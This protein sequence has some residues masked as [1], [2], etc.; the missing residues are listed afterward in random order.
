MHATI[1]V[2]LTVSIDDDKMIPLATLAEF[3]TDQNVES[4][5]L[6]GLVESL[7]ASRV[8]ALCGEKHAHGNGDQRFQRAGTDTRTAVTTAGEHEFNLH[9]VE[10][11]AAD[12]DEPSYFRPVEDV[13]SFD[14]QNRYQR[15]IAAKS[16][17]LATSLSYCDAAD[18]GD[19]IFERMPSPTTINR[20]IKEYG[21]KLKQFLPDFVADTDADA[22]IPDGTKCHSQD[23]DRSYHSV[24]ATLG[25]DTAEESRSLLDLSVNA[26][27]NETAADLYDIDAVTDDA[28]WSVTLMT[29]SLRPLPTNTAITNLI[30]S[31]LAER[32]TTTSGTTAVFSLD[33]RN[34]VVSE[35]I[36]EVFHLK[37]SVAKHRPNEEFAAIRERIART[38][39]RIEKTAWQ[40]EQYGSEKAAAVPFRV[41]KTG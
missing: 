2:R 10:D 3:I 4:V 37:N 6:E 24:Q 36:D 30:S 7:D 20:R 9:Y 34:E 40:L 35:V 8:E 18:H 25:E 5:L 27:W 13:L 31:T 21:G 39:E 23:D 29:A 19:G 26:D 16:V 12:H 11:T 32:W 33:R 41:L 22:V 1:D 28:E 15:D 38:T 14:G 17:D